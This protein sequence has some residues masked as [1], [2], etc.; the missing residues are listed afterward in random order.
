MKMQTIK[1][2]MPA[3]LL[4]VSAVLVTSCGNK[5]GGLPQ[6][7][8]FP[9]MSIGTTST[10]LDDSYP[11]VIKGKQDIEIRPKISGFITKVLV[12]EGSVVHAGQ[13]LFTI[14]DVTYR[15]A[16]NEAVATMNTAKAA[17]ATAELTYKNRLELHKQNIVG[18]YDLQTAHNSLVQA[19]AQLAQARAAVV[20]ARQNLAFC[21]VTSPSN[22]VVGSIPYRVGSLVSA[23]SAQALTTVSNIETMY[24]YFSMTE[25]QLL[26]LTRQS[27]GKNVAASFPAVKLQLADGSEYSQP[28]HVKTISGVIDQST[29][30]V[31]VRAD[32]ANPNHLLKSGGTG[33]IIIPRHATDAIIIPQN[34]TTE[35]QDKI[36]VY[37]VG[38]DNKVKYTEIKVDPKND[39]Q[40]YIV[41]SGL[42]VG[43]RIVTTGLTKLSDGMEISPITEAQYKKNIE[44]AEQLG[45]IQGNYKEMKKA[46]S[47]K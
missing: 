4:A 21:S 1:S 34:A 45:K 31:S 23:S 19:K 47:K 27:N 9:V 40:N 20:S 28:G 16:V 37:T 42:K 35:V 32:F 5:Q 18:D 6:S 11:A 10:Q 7:N 2:M 3:V 25:K 13:V 26:E 38:K 41:T 30:S 8:E 39:G 15:E 24:V 33:S 12:D 29:G 22:G 14:D 36:F 44:N 46:F 17:L 43:D